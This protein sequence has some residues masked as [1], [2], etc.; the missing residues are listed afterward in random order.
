MKKHLSWLYAPLAFILFLTACQKEQVSDLKSLKLDIESEA[1]VPSSTLT[2]ET[3]TNLTLVSAT[4]NG[5]NRNQVQ[6]NAVLGICWS[7]T[8]P[9]PSVEDNVIFTTAVEGKFS[10]NMTGLDALE[11]YYVRVFFA[12]NEVSPGKYANLR[13]GNVISFETITNEP[14]YLTWPSPGRNTVWNN[15]LGIRW[16]QITQGT[17]ETFARQ[18]IRPGLELV[19]K[20]PNPGGDA[21]TVGVRSQPVV[22]ELFDYFFEL[23]YNYYIGGNLTNNNPVMSDKFASP[24]EWAKIKY[25]GTTLSIERSTN[26][27]VSWEP[28]ANTSN[29]VTGAPY[30]IGFWSRGGGPNEIFIRLAQ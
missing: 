9:D 27:G 24:G 16:D 15:S 28:I 20:V 14:V 11:K 10:V 2:T 5:S 30:Y 1:I 19:V 3:I 13:Y 17:I 25:V 6:K 29:L 4:V 26:G 7:S 8:N 18:R 22:G 21:W 12:S 23:N